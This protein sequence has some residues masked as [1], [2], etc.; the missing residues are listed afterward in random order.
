[1]LEMPHP[2][3]FQRP[4]MGWVWI[5]TETAHSELKIIDHRHPTHLYVIHEKLYQIKQI[6]KFLQ[7]HIISGDML[8]ILI[9]DAD[10]HN[11]K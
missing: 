11:I 9:G 7:R 4:L 5:V 2:S 3:E 8:L 1:M 10:C 6:I